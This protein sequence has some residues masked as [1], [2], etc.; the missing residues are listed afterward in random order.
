MS[1]A[2]KA[3]YEISLTGAANV[4]NTVLPATG[5]FAGA[6]I[7]TAKKMDLDANTQATLGNKSPEK[8]EGLSIGPLLGNGQYLML[9]GTDNITA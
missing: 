4:S 6:V 5:A 3:V 9:A 1:P 7:K 8:W 2:D